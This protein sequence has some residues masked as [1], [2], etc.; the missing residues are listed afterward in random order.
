M[1][2]DGTLGSNEGLEEPLSASP[3]TVDPPLDS[4]E[5]SASHMNKLTLDS[6]S[7]VYSGEANL[8]DSERFDVSTDSVA[9]NQNVE[10]EQS[11]LGEIESGGDHEQVEVGDA[12]E[13]YDAEENPVQ[14]IDE[15][16]ELKEHTDASHEHPNGNQ[17]ESQTESRVESETESRVE[18]ETESRVK[19]ESRIKEE[20]NSLTEIE[21]NGQ[22]ADQEVDMR[23]Q[24][25]SVSD[26]L[27]PEVKL[28]FK[29]HTDSSEACQNEQKEALKTE[30]EAD[31]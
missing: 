25:V 23:T 21:K 26:K 14:K 29:V 6:Q 24:T 28:E 27:I 1:Q 7:P 18:S 19:S 10:V 17:L 16:K 4:I 30:V 3:S 8:D 13:F 15:P 31:S 20:G 12:N 5:I 2:K 22:V 9:D 11:R